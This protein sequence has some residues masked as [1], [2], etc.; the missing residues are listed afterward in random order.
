MFTLGNKTGHVL[1]HSP[2]L[3]FRVDG[4]EVGAAVVGLAEGLGSAV[5]LLLLDKKVAVAGEL[6]PS[7]R[8]LF[9]G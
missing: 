9:L 7:R 2:L 1:N 4:H 5:G 3:Q 6:L 8:T